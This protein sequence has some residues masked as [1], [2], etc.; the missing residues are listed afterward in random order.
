MPTGWEIT[1]WRQKQGESSLATKASKRGE[2]LARW[3]IYR[4]TFIDALI[5]EGKAYKIEEGPY[6]F[7]IIH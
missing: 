6:F 4:L 7:T 3:Q 2:R 5:D 1:V